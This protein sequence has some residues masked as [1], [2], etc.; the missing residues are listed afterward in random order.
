VSLASLQAI[1]R[2]AHSGV[3]IPKGVAISAACMALATRDVVYMRTLQWV[4]PERESLAHQL[5][6]GLFGKTPACCAETVGVLSVLE[7][8]FDIL[9][10]SVETLQ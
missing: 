7:H 10:C 5:S 9:I 8:S 3:V 6:T 2:D 4:I 1:A